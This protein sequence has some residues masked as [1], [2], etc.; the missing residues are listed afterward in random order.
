[1]RANRGHGTLLQA[2]GR[3]SLGRDVVA[4]TVI[5]GKPAPTKACAAEPNRAL[6]AAAAPAT[7][8]TA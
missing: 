6:P 4:L 3:S 1:M 7:T 5:A 8:A 2:D